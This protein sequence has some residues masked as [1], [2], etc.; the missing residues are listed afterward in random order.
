MIEVFIDVCPVN[1]PSKP[2]RKKIYSQDAKYEPENEADQQDIEN[3]GYGADE[4]VDHNLRE[5]RRRKTGN[6]QGTQQAL[7]LPSRDPT[8]RTGSPGLFC[9]YSEHPSPSPQ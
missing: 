9:L 8:G 6:T 1:A 7:H 2:P 3:G 5:A 4:G